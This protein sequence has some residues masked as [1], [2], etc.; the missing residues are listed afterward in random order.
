MAH[1]FSSD[2][3]NANNSTIVKSLAIAS[4]ETKS[5]SELISRFR[6]ES[7][8]TLIGPGYNSIRNKMSLY[9]DA[10]NKVSIICNNLR[11][12]IIAANYSALNAME[13]YEELNTDDLPEI[14]SLIEVSTSILNW[15]KTEVP[16]YDSKG[17]PTGTSHTIGSPELIAAYE[18]LI[19]ELNKLKGV[20]ERLGPKLDTARGM[21]TNSEND[22]RTFA[23]AVD[24]IAVSQFI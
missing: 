19:E 16:D 10:F 6:N 17:N 1:I 20:L 9:E 5:F 14:I 7:Q 2:L 23:N 22:S 4:E 8:Q 24:G 18:R 12:N 15:L 21:I 11:S 3:I 13:G